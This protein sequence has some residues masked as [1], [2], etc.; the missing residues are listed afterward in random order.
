MT[1]L[2]LSQFAARQHYREASQKARCAPV[3]TRNKANSE[4]REALHQWLAADLGIEW[5]GRAGE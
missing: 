4:K 5:K 2:P 3:G 1:A